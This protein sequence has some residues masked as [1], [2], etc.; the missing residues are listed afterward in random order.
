MTHSPPPPLVVT[1]LA[2]VI[3]ESETQGHSVTHA[4]RKIFE[5]TAMGFS[6]LD[7]QAQANLNHRYFGIYLET[8]DCVYFAL[9]GKNVLGYL[10]GAPSTLEIHFRLSPYLEEFRQ[11]IDL[12]FPAHLHLNLTQSARGKGVGSKLIQTFL[13]DWQTRIE[14][15]GV[16]IVT[17]AGDRNVGFYLRNGFREVDQRGKRLLM[18]RS[19]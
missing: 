15:R 3:S 2:S 5:E 1:S 6:S 8:P 4:A 13:A 9:E 11:E 7:S 18:G 14:P 10:V 12:R 16:H 17:A 19:F